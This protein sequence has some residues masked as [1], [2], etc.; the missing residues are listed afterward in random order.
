M[1]SERDPPNSVRSI[2]YAEITKACANLS[3]AELGK[4]RQVVDKHLKAKVGAPAGAFDLTFSDA[5]TLSDDEA[6]ITAWFNGSEKLPQPGYPSQG[7]AALRRWA[8][9][10]KDLTGELLAGAL[11][12]TGSSPMKIVLERR[13]RG[14]PSGGV[15]LLVDQ[16]KLAKQID[17]ESTGNVSDKVGDAVKKVGKSRSAGYEARAIGKRARSRRMKAM[18]DASKP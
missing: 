15:R 6:A 8:Q 9:A 2:T 4:L 3:V 18:P 10:Q 12:E 11:E 5:Q 16:L 17:A 13:R 7:R 1:G 14:R